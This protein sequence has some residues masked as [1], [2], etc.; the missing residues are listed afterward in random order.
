MGLITCFTCGLWQWSQS[1]DHGS[2]E[3]GMTA[4]QNPAGPSRGLTCLQSRMP[5]KFTLMYATFS[6]LYWKHGGVLPAAVEPGWHP[7]IILT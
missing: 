5:P 6:V 4:F 2:N 1:G 3:V 7:W